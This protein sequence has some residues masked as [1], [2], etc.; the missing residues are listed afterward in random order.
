MV[1]YTI[2]IDEAGR[3]PIAGPVAVGAVLIRD[4][5]R[6]MVQERVLA[7][8]KGK[9]RDS[10]KI[11]RQKREEIFRLAYVLEEEGFLVSA[12]GMAGVLL[13][14]EEGIVPAVSRAMKR[15]LDRLV[16]VEALPDRTFV[17]LDGGLKAPKEYIH[18]QTIIKGDEKELTIALASVMA[19]V[20]RDKYMQRVHHH[21][22]EY[23]FAQ[24]K[25]Y[26]TKEHFKLVRKHGLCPEHRTGFIK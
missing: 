24:H 3:G 22:P 18:Q 15:A 10:K 25:G 17:Q 12:V 11:S 26:G 21:Y 23:N 2:G 1:R 9:L 13:V 19:K 5:A 8:T 6:S 7:L 20:I 4:D 14:N 16:C